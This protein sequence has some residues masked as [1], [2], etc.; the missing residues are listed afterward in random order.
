M[1]YDGGF[2]YVVIDIGE[3]YIAFKR[4]LGGKTNRV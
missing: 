1:R 3:K 4:Y 2:T